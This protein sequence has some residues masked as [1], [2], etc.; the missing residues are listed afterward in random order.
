MLVAPTQSGVENVGGVAKIVFYI[1]FCYILFLFLLFAVY[2]ML[3]RESW[4]G[5]EGRDGRLVVGRAMRLSTRNEL[6]GLSLWQKN[7]KNE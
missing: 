4:L 5:G 1:L 7:D 2:A 6:D 3:F